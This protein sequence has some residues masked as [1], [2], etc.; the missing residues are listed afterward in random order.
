MGRF[1]SVVGGTGNPS[2]TRGDERRVRFYTSSTATR[3]PF[4]RGEGLVGRR[5][6]PGDCH[7]RRSRPRNDNE[8]TSGREPS[9]PLRS[10]SK[11]LFLTNWQRSIETP[12]QANRTRRRIGGTVESGLRSKSKCLAQQAFSPLIRQKSKIFAT[13]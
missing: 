4:P 10:L 11:N 9:R 3:S 13:K 6:I 8:I 2:P 5:I 1:Y 7:G 12:R